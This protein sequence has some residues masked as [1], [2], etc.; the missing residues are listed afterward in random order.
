MNNIKNHFANE[1]PVPLL[2]TLVGACT[3]SNIYQS[4]GFNWVCHITMILS[5]IIFI[6]YLKKIFFHLPTCKN[7]YKNTVPASLYG[8]FSMLLMILGS[9][10]FTYH[11]GIGKIMWSLGLVIH[12]VHILAFTYFHVIKGINKEMFVPSWFVTYNGIMVSCV[13]GGAMNAKPILTYIVYYGIVIYFILIPLM[14]FRLWKGEL[15]QPVFHTLAIVVAPCSL[16]VVSYI[17]VIGQPNF[18][19]LSVLYLC[20]LVS[21][22]FI[23]YQIPKFFSYSFTPGFAGLTFPMAIGIVASAKMSGYLMSNGM[24]M[25]GTIVNEIQGIQ[26]Y[27]TTAIIGFV[28]YNFGRHMRGL[29][30]GK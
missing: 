19:L 11:Q 12:V 10:Y 25:A 2:P 5:T 9:Y 18:I 24:E 27:I 21:L 22:C 20:V 1:I 14:I 26:I 15:K 7:E 29:M 23:L 3:L 28:L 8:A 17:N 16:C 6:L 30:T 4:L 13:V